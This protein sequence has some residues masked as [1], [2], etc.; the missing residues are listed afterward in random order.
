VGGTA[1]ALGTAVSVGGGC[2]GKAV[3]AIVVAVAVQPAK[4]MLKAVNINNLT[5]RIGLLII[6]S[7][8]YLSTLIIG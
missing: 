1:V 3:G 8:C 6:L 2:V 5:E 4:K 7:S